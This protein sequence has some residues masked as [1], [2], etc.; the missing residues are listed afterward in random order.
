MAVECSWPHEHS[1]TFPR[2]FAGHLAVTKD[3]RGPLRWRRG[4]PLPH[5]DLDCLKFAR[6]RPCSH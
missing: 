3:E 5:L 2:R 4:G 6:H 1:V